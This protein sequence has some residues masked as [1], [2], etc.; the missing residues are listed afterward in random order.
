MGYELWLTGHERGGL[1]VYAERLEVRGRGG[2][3][4]IGLVPDLIEEASYVTRQSKET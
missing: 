4:R 3:W 1:G 2:T